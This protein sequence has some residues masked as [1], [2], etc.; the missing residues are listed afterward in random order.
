MNNEYVIRIQGQLVAVSE[1]IYKSY[2]AMKNHEEYLEKKD[3]LCGKVLYSDLDTEDIQGEDAIPDLLTPSVEDIIETALM[4]EKLRECIKVLS[5]AEQELVKNL[6]FQEK[7]QAQLARETGVK[8]QTYSYREKRI[9]E[10]LKK[11]LEK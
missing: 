5:V 7:S 2:Y 3:L 9:L 1:E 11:L 10:K 8:Q 6:Y 4:I